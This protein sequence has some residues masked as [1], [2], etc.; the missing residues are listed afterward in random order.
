MF[1][2]VS[3]IIPAY[4][5]EMTIEDLV[6]SVSQQTFPKDDYEIII[7]NDCSTDRTS[8][9]LIELQHSF[10]FKILSHE[11]NQG[12][13]CTRNTGIK[14]STGRILIFI[15]SDMTVGD[16]YI[17]N[18][19]NFHNKK[20]VV[21]V[22]GGI[23]PAEQLKIDKY[24]KYLYKTKR[25]I[26]KYSLQKPIPFNA[27]IFG[28]TS[29]K[30]EVIAECGMFDEN[31]KIYGGEDTEFAFRINQKYPQGLFATCALRAKHN[32]Y[33]TFY[34]SLKNLSNFAKTNIPYIIRKHPQMSRL[35]GIKYL[36]KNYDNSTIFHRVI[37]NIICLHTFYYVSKIFYNLS[38]FPLSAIFTRMMMA[39]KLFRG[40]KKGLSK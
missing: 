15:D 5:A 16:H 2:K 7:V 17:E 13:A 6:K 36:S 3:I 18:H 40:I 20:Q 30:R 37:G 26:K 38:P 27:F 24:Q 25:G 28:N 39:S 23:L 11:K 8:E 9:I 33:R 31:I 21:G 34:D 32:H 19:V 1:Y 35:Y 22:L 12:L 4:N 29:I 10:N 14:N